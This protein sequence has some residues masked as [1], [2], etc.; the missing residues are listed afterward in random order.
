[1]KPVETLRWIAFVAGQ[2]EQIAMARRHEQVAGLDC[3]GVEPVR[4]DLDL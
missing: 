4:E 2:E 3:S 1:M